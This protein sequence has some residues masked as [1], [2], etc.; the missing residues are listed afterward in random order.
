MEMDL[1]SSNWGFAPPYWTSKIDNVYAVREDGLD[2]DVGVVE[3]M[4]YFA[5]GEIMEIMLE[6][7][8][9]SPDLQEKQKVLDYITWENMVRDWKMFDKK[10]MDEDS[11]WNEGDSWD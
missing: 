4:C 2:L 3:M 11:S 10:E 6:N 7:A 8:F 9:C 1:R 5:R